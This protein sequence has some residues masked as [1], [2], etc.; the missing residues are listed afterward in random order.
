MAFPGKGRCKLNSYASAVENPGL[1][2]IAGLICDCHGIKVSFCDPGSHRSI[3][4]VELLDLLI[5]VRRLA[6]EACSP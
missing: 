3:D 4:K 1:P 6:I 2:R 5:G